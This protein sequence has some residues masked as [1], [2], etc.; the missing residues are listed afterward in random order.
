MSALRN[1]LVI[2][3]IAALLG[4]EV[5]LA[6]SVPPGLTPG[7]VPAPPLLYR[8]VPVMAPLGDPIV[9]NSLRVVRA[10]DPNGTEAL[11]VATLRSVPPLS[12]GGQPQL[13]NLAK[14]TRPESAAAVAVGPLQPG[15]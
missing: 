9:P 5:A 15:P 2:A 1:V 10:L 6:Q 11:P 4:P 3:A 7:P 12:P 8:S 14:V 13:A